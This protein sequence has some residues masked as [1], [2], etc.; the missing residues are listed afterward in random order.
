MAMGSARGLEWAQEGRIEE[1]GGREVRCKLQAQCT[2]TRSDRGCSRLLCRKWGRG[3]LSLFLLLG[4]SPF[5]LSL[6]RWPESDVGEREGG[7][8]RECA[9]EDVVI[10]DVLCCASRRARAATT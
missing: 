4:R 5:V 7:M 2:R 10:N 6:V 9:A 8:G 3:C 1:K